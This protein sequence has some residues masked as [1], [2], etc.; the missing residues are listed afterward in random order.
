MVR[1]VGIL[2]LAKALQ[3]IFSKMSKVSWARSTSKLT[4]RHHLLLWSLVLHKLSLSN[5][6]SSVWT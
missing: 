1:S 4:I 3:A 6:D 5:F 2:L